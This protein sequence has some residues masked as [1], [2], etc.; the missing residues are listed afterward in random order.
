MWIDV[1]EIITRID[2]NLSSKLHDRGIYNS[3]APVR[4]ANEYSSVDEAAMVDSEFQEEVR[5]LIF[6]FRRDVCRGYVHRKK[7]NKDVKEQRI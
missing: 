5:N 6:A 3:S 1:H 2:I 4:Y 7:F